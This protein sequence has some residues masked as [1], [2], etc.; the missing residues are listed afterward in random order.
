MGEGKI[1]KI[2]SPSNN[3]EK[4]VVFS[5]CKQGKCE[6]CSN[7]VIISRNKFQQKNYAFGIPQLHYPGVDKS[8]NQIRINRERLMARELPVEIKT[9]KSDDES[10]LAL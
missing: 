8:A 5:F 2:L 3:N 6:Y 10:E 9:G 4:V 7:L 1:A